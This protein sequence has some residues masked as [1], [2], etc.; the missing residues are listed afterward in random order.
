LNKLLL[1]NKNTILF[2]IV[3]SSLILLLYIYRE[4]YFLDEVVK[5]KNNI[6]LL[7][8]DSSDLIKPKFSINRKTD[9]I[10]VSANE[11]N[12]VT[13]DK[14]LLNNEVEFK[15]ENFKITSNKATFNKKHQ[16]ASSDTFTEFESEGAIISSQGFNITDS[17]NV[18]S[19]K[20]KTKI[21]LSK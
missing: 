20:G 11:G 1:L 13:K 2:L 7:S 9:N 16:T 18:I 21:I 15:T 6:E 3:L 14:I 17:G 10:T 19:F 4:N 12:F 8:L 5:D